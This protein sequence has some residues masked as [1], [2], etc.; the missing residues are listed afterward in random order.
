MPALMIPAGWVECT[1]ASGDR[2]VED[3]DSPI[4]GRVIPHLNSAAESMP[5]GKFLRGSTVSGIHEQDSLQGHAHTIGT[6]YG[7]ELMGPLV[8]QLPEG[9]Q[10]WGSS[11]QRRNRPGKQ[12]YFAR[13]IIDD[14]SNGSVRIGKETRPVNMSVVWIM[15]IK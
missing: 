9:P 6:L 3:P 7:S 1:N 2:I 8:E 12:N 4:T 10:A 11:V 5:G 14:G 15:R 13:S